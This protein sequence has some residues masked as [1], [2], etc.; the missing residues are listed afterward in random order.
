MYCIKKQ[1]S[2]NYKNEISNIIQKSNR[3]PRIIET[4][5]E[6]EFADKIFTEFAKSKDNKRYRRYTSKVAVFVELFNRT[7]RDLLKEPVFNERNAN[8]VDDL[9]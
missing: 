1:N 4:D 2:W 9:P 7:I 6:E 5:E 3:K 8:W